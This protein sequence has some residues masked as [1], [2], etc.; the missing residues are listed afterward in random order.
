[1]FLSFFVLYSMAAFIV[2]FVV[3]FVAV[4]IKV[5]S[6]E[7]AMRRLSIHLTSRQKLPKE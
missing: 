1:M 6:V 2:F 7:V 5:T 3:V 4:D